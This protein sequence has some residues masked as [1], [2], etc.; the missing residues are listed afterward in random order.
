MGLLD[1]LRRKPSPDAPGTKRKSARRIVCACGA[2]FASEAKHHRH[3][4]EA[5]PEHRH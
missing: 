1:R 3:L 2:E 5:H 4:H